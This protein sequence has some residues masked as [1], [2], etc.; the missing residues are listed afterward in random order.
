MRQVPVR[1]EFVPGVKN[2]PFENV[3][4][5]AGWT[6]DGQPSEE[7]QQLPMSRVGVLDGQVRFVAEFCFPETFLGHSYRWGVLVDS[8]GR[9]DLWGIMTEARDPA[10]AERYCWFS[11]RG[12]MESLQSIQTETY[13][14]THCRRLGANKQHFG[15]GSRPGIHFA[16]WAPHARKVE[17]V[18]GTIWDARQ[19][20]SIATRGPLPIREICG[21][22]I[23]DDGTGIDLTR[24]P[25]AMHRG[26]DGVWMTDPEDPALSDFSQFDHGPYMFRVTKDDGTVVYRTDLYSR[27]QIGSGLGTNNPQGKPYFGQVTQ[28]DGT[29]SCSVVVDP[30]VVSREFQEWCED[31]GTWVP[32]WPEQHFLTDEQFWVDEFDPARPVPKRIEELV[33]YELHIGALGF[34]KDG[35]GTIE[36]AIGLLSYLED[37]GVNAIELLPM[38][39]FGG[40]RHFWGY[41]TSHYFAIEYS[42]GGRDKFKH[43]IRECHRR[44]FAVIMDVVYNHYVHAAERAQ[45]LFDSNSHDKNIYYWYE[46]TPFHYPDYER[47]AAQA[48]DGHEQNSPAPGH[49]GYIDNLSTGYAPAYHEEM[50][51][52]LFISSAVSLMQEF[53]VDG[54]RVDQTTSIHSYNRRHADGLPMPHVNAFGVKFLR[55]LTSTL[56]LINPSILLIAEDHSG[57]DRVTAPVEHGGLGFHSAWFADFYHHLIG[58]AADKGVEWAKLLKTIGSGYD[59]PLAIERFAKT[60]TQTGPDKIVYHESHDEA[61]NAAGTERTVRTAA[62]GASPADIYANARALV[63]A[64]ISLFSAGT[65]MFLFGEEVGVDAPFL[66]GEILEHR[67]DLQ[68]LRLGRGC[69]MFATY[70]NWIRLRRA[71]GGLRSRHLCVVHAH[72][73]NRIIA[74]CRWAD[75]EDARWLIV[76]NLANHGYVN[77]YRLEL[78]KQPGQGQWTVESASRLAGD[79]APAKVLNQFDLAHSTQLD[80]LVPPVSFTVLRWSL[81]KPVMD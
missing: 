81:Q 41:S 25:F 49:G 7:C 72:D 10:S 56:L 54:F 71:H 2:P 28:L 68:S 15:N 31:Q 24:G 37:L 55:E 18:L 20:P 60:L 34:G 76:V 14:L 69:D 48:R 40:D 3:R 53:H 47:L 52:K 80:L 12:S 65:P 35:V 4:L 73:E 13:Y 6:G 22:Y 39:E 61:G 64:G 19:G 29:V 79:H 74:W 32:A 45:W 66:Y 21:G 17:V 26:S 42:G 23:A 8:M 46:G 36:N 67:V 44:G 50:V 75:D 77:G 43:F 33:I 1:F 16:C 62:G 57:W 58:D 78:P 63:V 59:G 5:V 51:R 38:S 11:L 9:R 30:D 27:C 70:A